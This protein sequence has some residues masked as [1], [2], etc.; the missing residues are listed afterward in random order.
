MEKK[1]EEKKEEN[2]SMRETFLLLFKESKTI[3]LQ[4]H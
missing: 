1:K 4:L 2:R 3:P